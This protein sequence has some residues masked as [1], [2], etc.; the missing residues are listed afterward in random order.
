[1]EANHEM[2]VLTPEE[3]MGDIVGLTETDRRGNSY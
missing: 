2:E 3:N 1:M